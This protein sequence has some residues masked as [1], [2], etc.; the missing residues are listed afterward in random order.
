MRIW[1]LDP[2]YLDRQGLTAGWR[3][4]LL[5]QAVLAGRTRGYRHHPQLTRFREQPDPLAAVGE[6]LAGVAEEATRRGYRYNVTKILHPPAGS[7]G[8][9][10][11]GSAALPAAGSAAL[12][13]AGSPA[14]PAAGSP[15]VPRIPVTDGQL[16]H[17]W[18]HLLA[19]LA[20]RDPARRERLADVAAPAVHRLFVVV[21]GPVEAWEVVTDAK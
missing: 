10:T 11:D 3:E 4:A 20:V 13:A 16:A 12:P 15:G 21:P 1:S 19:K 17:E 9:P 8:V 5:A 2:A 7:P 14:L 18:R 6:Y